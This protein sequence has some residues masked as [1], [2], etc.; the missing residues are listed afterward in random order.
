MTIGGDVMNNNLVID[1]VRQF[2]TPLYLYDSNLIC[3]NY[4]ILKKSL[5]DNFEIFFSMKAN[6]LLG[7]CELFKKLGSNIEVASGG[8]L[9][10][11]LTAGFNPEQIIFTSP[12]KTVEE[13]DYAIETG[14]YSINAESL[15][16]ILLINDIGKSKS[17]TVDISVRINPDFDISGASIKMTG[18]ATQFGVDQKHAEN[19]FNK[20]ADLTNVNIIGIHVYTGTQVLKADNIVSNMEEIIKLAINMSSIG[21]FE[22]KFLDL[23]GGF[24]IPYFNNE[25]HLDMDILRKGIAGVWQKYREK[26]QG[27]RVA[28]ES[29][30][31]L[32]AE[33]GSYLTKVIYCKENK[34]KRYIICDGGSNQHANSAFLGRYIRNNFPMR[35]LGK[36][37]EKVETEV[38]GPLCTPT[39][40]IGQR[41]MLPEASPGDI[42]IVE[43]SGA[44]GLTDS[45]I[46]F[47]SHS[48]PAEVMLYNGN[49]SVLRERGEKEDLLNR[50]KGLPNPPGKYEGTL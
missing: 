15:E 37:T 44:Y 22:L 40:V 30:R 39:D 28:V 49:I 31:Y 25:T 10:T 5:P 21:G 45:P 38:V 20:V 43:K 26:L 1:A 36:D 41:V 19:M 32:L 27:T 4:N 12:G 3:N 34:G 2:G 47:L 7:I 46:L 13:L 48:M 33:A 8:E 23:G 6:P 17:K 50:Q 29:G 9:Y 42:L 24:G 16:E 11:A 35:I 18:V 14:I